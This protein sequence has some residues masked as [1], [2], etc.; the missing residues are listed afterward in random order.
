MVNMAEKV[1]FCD[2]YKHGEFGIVLRFGS[3]LDMYCLEGT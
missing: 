3:I 2:L 1:Y